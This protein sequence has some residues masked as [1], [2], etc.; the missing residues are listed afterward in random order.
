MKLTRNKILEL[1]AEQIGVEPEDLNVDDFFEEDLHMTNADLTDFA[2]KLEQF[3]LEPNEID[4]GTIE[5]LGD[6]FETLGF[7]LE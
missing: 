1:L 6:L 3:G 4:F 2:H 5:T 7:T